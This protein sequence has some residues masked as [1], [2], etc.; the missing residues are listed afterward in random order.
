MAAEMPTQRASHPPAL[1]VNNSNGTF[2]MS[3]VNA[4]AASSPFITSMEKINDY[5]AGSYLVDLLDTV[6]TI[7]R[8]GHFQFFTSNSLRNILLYDCVIV[9]DHHNASHITFRL[10][11]TLFLSDEASDRMELVYR[12]VSPVSIVAE[13]LV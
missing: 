6:S 2:G 9:N 1:L 5:E 8:I 7:H 4:R 11:T 10:P 12:R 3:N 13:T